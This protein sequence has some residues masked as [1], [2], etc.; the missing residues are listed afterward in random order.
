MNNGKNYSVLDVLTILST[1]LQLE[2][3]EAEMKAAGNDDLMEELQRQ[4]REY[5]D[6]IIQNQ[7]QILKNQQL[8]IDRLER[9]ALDI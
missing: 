6:K 8:I 4:D 7:E 9:Q 2:N 5:L 1:I 3:Y